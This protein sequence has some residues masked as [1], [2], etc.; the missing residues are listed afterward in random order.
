MSEEIQKQESLELIPDALL[1]PVLKLNDREQKFCELVADGHSWSDAVREAGYNST[2]P[3]RY[4]R[5][6]RDKQKIRNEI[7]RLVA[8]REGFVKVDDA[9]V[10]K[11]LMGIINADISDFIDE[12]GYLF[13]PEVLRNMP[14]HKTKAIQSIKQTIAKDGSVVTEVKLY[15]KL[16]AI[17]KVAKHVKF[18]KDEED[19]DSKKV[20]NLI[21][22]GTIVNIS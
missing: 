5:E 3:A 13:S 4:A 6:L 1:T 17:D 15:D 7:S 11:E 14:P 22:P 8:E 10:L 12:D 9:R 18:Y 21:L 16:S 20:I 2:N 19:P